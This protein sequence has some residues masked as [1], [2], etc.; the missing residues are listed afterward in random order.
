MSSFTFG[1]TGL[2]YCTLVM[3]RL[4]FKDLA[5]CQ[6]N[7]NAVSILISWKNECRPYLIW[8]GATFNNSTQLPFPT[9]R[10]PNIALRKGLTV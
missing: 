9:L 3:G 6:L 5:Q 4:L 10:L 8:P 1:Q 2:F 7:Y